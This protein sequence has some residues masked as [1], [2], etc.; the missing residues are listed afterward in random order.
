MNI[1]LLALFGMNDKYCEICR[2]P[3]SPPFVIQ[4]ENGEYAECCTHCYEGLDTC[5]TCANNIANCAY[6]TDPSPLEKV[7]CKTERNGPVVKTYYTQN[8]ERM[9]ITCQECK[10]YQDNEC[11][12]A[13]YSYTKN[14]ICKHYQV[15]ILS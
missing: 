12:K 15:K 8:P 1:L 3:G 5:R 13:K 9:A 2:K 7:I 11:Q 4:L 10:C 14:T 6:V